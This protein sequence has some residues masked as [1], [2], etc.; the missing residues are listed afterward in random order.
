MRI[1]AEEI[2]IIMIIMIWVVPVFGR[3]VTMIV[4]CHFTLGSS[5]DSLHLQKEK[6]EERERNLQKAKTE[7]G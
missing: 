4:C 6:K 1:F 7:T 2:S 5:K 3:P